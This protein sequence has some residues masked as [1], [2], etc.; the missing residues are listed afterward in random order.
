MELKG[1]TEHN[2]IHCNNAIPMANLKMK[3]EFK[4]ELKHINS[5]I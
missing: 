2:A 1:D 3:V 4:V 5:C